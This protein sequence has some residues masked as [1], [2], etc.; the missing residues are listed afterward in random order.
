[1]VSSAW[2]PERQLCSL[3]IHD[4]CQD[5]YRHVIKICEFTLYKCE[6][7]GMVSVGN[8]VEAVDEIFS[9]SC[10]A[11][12]NIPLVL[13]QAFLKTISQWSVDQDKRSQHLNRCTANLW[14]YAEWRDCCIVLFQRPWLCANAW[15]SVTSSF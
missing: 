7:P 3:E 2:Q 14:L 9:R 6:P 1:M 5:I 12:V 11:A 8:L 4:G 13:E 15:A 10:I